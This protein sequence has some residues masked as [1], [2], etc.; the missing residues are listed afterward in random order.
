[1]VTKYTQKMKRVC[2]V[3]TSDGITSKVVKGSIWTLIGQ[4]LPLLT[5]LV[6]TPIV[7]RFLGSE[8]YGVLVVIGL[9]PAYFSFADFGMG[10]ASTKF[11]S[12]AYGKGNRAGEAAIVWTASAVALTSSLFVAVPIF[13]FSD[14]I[15]SV[16]F[17]IPEQYCRIS[18]LGVK[19]TSVSFVFAILSGVVN[20]PLLAR[21]RM[22]LNTL[23]TALPRVFMGIATPIVLY[24][25]GFVLEAVWIA[26][27]AA[28]LALVGTLFSSFRLLP[29]ILRPRLNREMIG[30]MLRFGGGWLI[31]MIASI[32]LI[33][34]EKFFLPRY[35]SVQALAHYSIAFTFANMTTMFSWALTQSLIPAFSV[36]TGQKKKRE[37]DALF[38]RGIRLNLILLP[39]TVM[40]L[41]VVAKPFFTI[42]AGPEF[43][44]ESSL[45][46]YVLL[47]GLFFNIL[48]LVAY[49]TLTA[50]GRSDLLAKLY[51]CELIVYAFVVI[52]LVRSLGI[53][54][55]ALAW[56]LRV[57]IDAFITI[58]LAKRSAEIAFSFVAYLWN[59]IIGITILSPPVI[60]AVAYD[61]FS[62]WLIP[63]VLGSL[64]GYFYFSWRRSTQRIER[65]WFEDKL[66]GLF[67]LPKS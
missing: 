22:D 62:L 17:N 6:S 35:V 1:M 45:P 52:W 36:M 23:V 56:S 46:F 38:E 19:I 7:I 48:S 5:S 47:V 25:G 31:A 42:W 8:A 3:D 55:A 32:Q 66:T 37:F 50:T 67:G 61:N 18:S 60:L 59:L 65:D 30:P 51:W 9:I 54:G 21:L 11:G 14:W 26:F 41:F 53:V 13:L 58:W 28:V 64:V 29:E 43:G 33:N 2:T 44:Q 24:L 63:A 15:V 40:F 27:L 16:W 10:V 39:P 49:S 34:L 20:T 57:T 4:I 12:E